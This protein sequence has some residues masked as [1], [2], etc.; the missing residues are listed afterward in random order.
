MKKIIKRSRLIAIFFLPM[1]FF[2]IATVVS[3]KAPVLFDTIVAVRTL[4]IG[5][6]ITEADVKLV[7]SEKRDKRT[8]TTVLEVVGKR[9][10]RPISAG[11]QVKT[12]YLSEG[13]AVKSGDSVLI[14]AKKKNMKL[15]V[16]GRV[17]EDAEVGEIVAVEN[18]KS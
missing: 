6:V 5:E 7:T 8:A 14:V 17:T 15:T 13:S 10:I 2:T 11:F 9:T 4:A 1:I 18:V 16:A 12:N 3:A